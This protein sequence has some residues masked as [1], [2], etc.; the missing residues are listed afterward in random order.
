M[1][2]FNQ[3][4]SIGLSRI[5]SWRRGGFGAHGN[6]GKHENEVLDITLILHKWALSVTLW[7]IGRWARFLRWM[8]GE[9]W[10]R[11]LVEPLGSEE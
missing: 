6:G 8:P 3:R 4:L 11:Y 7:R 10:S 9:P 2:L 1:W 5:R